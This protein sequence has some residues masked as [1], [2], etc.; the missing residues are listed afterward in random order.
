MWLFNLFDTKVTAAAL[1]ELADLKCL[2]ALVL[3][4]TKV[5]DTGRSASC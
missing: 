4:G 5:T 3:S 2:R 1:K